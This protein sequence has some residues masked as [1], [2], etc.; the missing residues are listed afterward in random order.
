MVPVHSRWTS[1]APVLFE[2]DSYDYDKG[3][4]VGE[5]ID[6]SMDHRGFCRWSQWALLSVVWR[7]EARMAEHDLTCKSQEDFIYCVLTCYGGWLM[8]NLL[9]YHVV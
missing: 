6:E 9:F 4:A 7:E 1:E 8:S 5:T 3:A 2:M